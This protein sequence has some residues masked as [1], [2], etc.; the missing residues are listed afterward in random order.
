MAQQVGLHLV[1]VM[2]GHLGQGVAGSVDQ[3]PLAQAVGECPVEGA[4]QPGG[5]VA[6]PQQRCPQATLL[7]V[8][9][10]VVPG[11][12]GLRCRGR[13]THEYRFAVDID[14][15]GG[16]YRLGR[17]AGV[18]LEVAAV[19]EQVV[20]PHHAQIAVPPRLELLADP[21]ADAAD[22]RLRQCRLRPQHLG[23]GGLDVP[24]GQA[25]HPAGDDQRLQRVGAGHAGA[26]QPRAERLV[27]AAQLGRC[28]STGPIVVF[29]AADGCQPLREP[30]RPWS[31]RRW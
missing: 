3:T 8:G 10:E 30:G 11:V 16:Q 25:T 15:P 4:G 12:G 26:E 31:V 22:R 18:H 23:Q 13:Q 20:Q 9:Q 1:L 27:G 21:L 7:E 19:Q 2:G 29:T 6:D 17:R 14:A 28:S 5:A 24:V